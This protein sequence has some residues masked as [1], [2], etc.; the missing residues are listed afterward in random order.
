MI[1]EYIKENFYKSDYCD[2]QYSAI[3]FS[4]LNA[5]KLAT[6]VN[7]TRCERTRN[8]NEIVVGEIRMRVEEEKA[9]MS[10]WSNYRT[11]PSESSEI[12][13]VGDL[14]TQEVAI[15]CICARKKISAM[16]T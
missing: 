11:K 7:E 14:S 2:D 16:F 3:L 13:A 9:E 6:D 15:C 8:T 12:L 5:E 10:M 4:L 1:E